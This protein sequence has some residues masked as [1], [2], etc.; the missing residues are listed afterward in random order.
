MMAPRDLLRFAHLF[1]EE[2]VRVGVFVGELIFEI[3]NNPFRPSPTIA[4]AVL[5][6]DGGIVTKLAQSAY[7]ERQMPEATLDPA[8]LA[9]LADALE[10]AGCDHADLLEHLRGGYH[11]VRGC[12]AVDVVLGLK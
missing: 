1:R 8:R 6:F 3:F 7:D 5:A 11:H 12:W 9:V 10:E 2:P 4:P